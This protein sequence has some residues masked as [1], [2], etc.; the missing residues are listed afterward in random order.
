MPY[1][2]DEPRGPMDSSFGIVGDDQ[3]FRCPGE[4]QVKEIVFLRQPFGVHRRH[5]A[6]DDVICGVYDY[7]MAP[8]LSQGS[9]ESAEGNS[10]G[11][12]IET[13][14]RAVRQHSRWNAPVQEDLCYTRYGGVS[15]GQDRHFVKGT[16]IPLP[17]LHVPYQP[18][19]QLLQIMLMFHQDWPVAFREAAEPWRSE[20]N[21]R[22]RLLP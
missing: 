3:R 12:G 11:E 9:V 22:H 20:G 17:V 4:C 5:A 15:P 14:P 10:V 19:V 2:I 6:G 7:H 21:G 1:R 13:L 8:M 18:G 16:S